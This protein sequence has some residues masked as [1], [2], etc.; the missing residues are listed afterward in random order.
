M[1]N[2]AIVNC[3]CQDNMMT[4]PAPCPTPIGCA[5]PQKCSEI[6]DAECIIYTG[7]PII[8]NSFTIVTP[9]TPVSEVLNII[10]EYFCSA[11]VPMIATS[12]LY[13]IGDYVVSA[14]GIICHRYL[15]SG[16]QHYI[17]V[18][19]EDLSAGTIFGVETTPVVTNI[20]DGETNTV[21]L[22]ASGSKT[23]A[24]LCSQSVR[25]LK[26]DWYL[27]S[28]REIAFFFSYA[29]TRSFSTFTLPPGST[30]ILTSIGYWTSTLPTA[31]G[32]FNRSDFYGVSASQFNAN[33]AVRA[34][35]TFTV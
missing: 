19:T 18:D 28:L 21:N 31:D 30:S 2:C 5:N 11:I 10:T 27:P 26:N 12:Y 22:V 13:E 35:R 17:V 32:A 24:I 6:F 33:Y 16:V 7:D 29:V 1:S 9:N 34:V 25:N 23:A 4:T 14:G 3:G 8:C 20:W 15:V